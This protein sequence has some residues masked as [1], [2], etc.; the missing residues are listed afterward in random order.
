[1]KDAIVL[2]NVTKSF[3]YKTHKGLKGLL[4]P[5]NKIVTAVD[6]ISFH[7]PRGEAVAFIGPNGAGKST[8]IKMLSGILQPS[9]G[10]VS[11]LGLTPSEQR[12]ELAMRI[13]TV[14]GQRSQLVFN[15]PL[16]DSFLLTAEMYQVPKATAAKRIQRLVD[17]FDL[18]PFIDQP[19]RKLSLGQRMR[20][21]VANS[22]IHNPDIIFLDEPTIGLDIVAKR[23]L[24]QVIKFINKEQ[25]TTVFLTSHDVGDIE[26]VCTRTMIVGDGKIIIDAQ[27][28]ELKKNHFNSKSVSV[29]PAYEPP[30]KLVVAGYSARLQEGRLLFDVDTSKTPLKEFLQL[31]LDKVDIADVT[32]Q[33]AALEDIIHELYTKG[34]Q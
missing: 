31:L 22:L 4:K 3:S 15:L 17:Q 12:R 8:T 1:V 10:N 2:E 23:K 29:V 32:I 6:D 34:V 20:A 24:R 27:T 18:E 33:D 21:E 16:T 26:E 30:T 19:V 7:V 25:G 14:F 9:S 5:D 11:V 28:A 13:G